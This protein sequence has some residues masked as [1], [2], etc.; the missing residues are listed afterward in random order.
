LPPSRS[1][2]SLLPST[3][4]YTYLGIRVPPSIASN[5]GLSL[6]IAPQVPPSRAG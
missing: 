2:R 5:R 3:K 6:G 4:S 1:L